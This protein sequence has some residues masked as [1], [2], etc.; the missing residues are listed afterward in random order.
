VVADT[1]IPT[2]IKT[3]PKSL[4]D[5]LRNLQVNY[6]LHAGDICIPSVVQELS[7][8]APVTA[9]R[10]NSDVIFGDTLPLVQFLEFNGVQVA[11][12]HGCGTTWDYLRDRWRYAIHGYKADRYI[13]LAEKF[14]MDAQVVVFGHSHRPQ[15]EI[16]GGRLFFNPGSACFAS[17]EGGSPSI[18]LLQIDASG[19]VQADIIHLPGNLVYKPYIRK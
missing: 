16:R 2:R 11:L 15:K 3:M 17:P 13:K 18:G 8:I 14:S 6:M 5:E 19:N 1:H 12:T 10:G 9:A 4:L 7:T